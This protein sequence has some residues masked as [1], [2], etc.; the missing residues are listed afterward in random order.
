[1]GFHRWPIWIISELRI[2]WIQQIMAI[3][4]Q[5]KMKHNT[6]LFWK[7]M[8]QHIPSVLNRYISKAAF[9]LLTNTFILLMQLWFTGSFLIYSIKLFAFLW[10]WNELQSILLFLWHRIRTSLHQSERMR[11]HCCSQYI[12]R[13]KSE[14]YQQFEWNIWPQK[15]V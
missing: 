6:S 9:E 5:E 13:R 1:M 3:Q 10:C 2:F 12:K 14:M 11:H 8:H 7:K 15:S 4:F